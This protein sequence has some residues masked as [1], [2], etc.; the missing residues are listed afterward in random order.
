MLGPL[1]IPQIPPGSPPSVALSTFGAANGCFTSAPDAYSNITLTKVKKQDPGPDPVLNQDY[2]IDIVGPE[3]PDPDLDHRGAGEREPDYT[4]R[5]DWAKG[6]LCGIPPAG[7]Y[8]GHCITVE[9]VEVQ[10]RR[11]ARAAGRPIPT[12]GPS[13]SAIERSRAHVCP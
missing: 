6:G 13:S 4:L 5:F 1:S 11:D 8:S 2:S 7:N 12:S 9:V 3:E 10:D